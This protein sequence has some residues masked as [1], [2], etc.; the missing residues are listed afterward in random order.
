MYVLSGNVSYLKSENCKRM[1]KLLFTLLALLMLITACVK[2]TIPYIPPVNENFD[3]KTTE[4]VSIK[5]P[6]EIQGKASLSG[7]TKTDS[8]ASTVK[9]YSSALYSESSFIASGAVYQGNDFETVMDL[10]KGT[11]Q[12]F[13]KIV[14]PRGLVTLSTYDVIGNKAVKSLSRSLSVKGGTPE[15]IGGEPIVPKPKFPAGYDVTIRNASELPAILTGNR[16]YFI[17]EGVSI[18]VNNVNLFSNWQTGNLPVLYVKGNFVM[19]NRAKT[20]LSF[21]SV[22]VLSGGS[23]TFRGRIDMGWSGENML[24]VYVQNGGR[25]IMEQG[26]DAG[27]KGLG[28]VNEGALMVKGSNMS[29]LGGGVLFYNTAEANFVNNKIQFTGN[30]TV[31]Y[32]MSDINAKEIEINSGASF[33]NYKNGDVACE[34]TLHVDNSCF[35]KNAGSVESDQMNLV[36][37]ASFYNYEN[38]NKPG[39]VVVKNLTMTNSDTYLYQHGFFTVE[40]TYKAKGKIDN[41]GRM[42][43]STIT[44]GSTANFYCYKGSLIKTEYLSSINHATFNMESESIVFVY[45]NG[46]GNG[47][48][49]NWN[50]KFINNNSNGVEYALVLWG[51]SDKKEDNT[52]INSKGEVSFYGNIENHCPKKSDAQNKKYTNDLCESNAYWGGREHNIPET[53]YNQGFGTTGGNDP[54]DADGDG[55]PEGED[56]D[57]DDPLVTHVSYFPSATTWATY[58]FEDLWP[59]TGDYDMNDIVLGFRIAYYSKGALSA[60]NNHV[61]YMDFD[62]KLRAVGSQMQLALGMQLDDIIPTMISKI[63]NDNTALGNAP[64]NK[65]AGGLESGQT[66]AVFALFNNPAELYGMSTGLNVYKDVNAATVVPV[67]K[68]VRIKF[69]SAVPKEN[70]VVAAMNPFVV[71]SETVLDRGKEIHLATNLP[72]D[73]VNRNYFSDGFVSAANPYK[74]NNGMVWGYMVPAE[75]R[76]PVEMSAITKVY[77]NFEKWYQSAGMEHTNWYDASIPGNVVEE[78]LYDH[79]WK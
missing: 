35:F 19:E 60:T 69:A 58:L 15:N 16:T 62:W 31:C 45:K 52:I 11:T 36:S 24:A 68:K 38:G 14:S 67:I 1:N 4:P 49:N 61:V 9:I 55:V 25:L 10:A 42:E 20:P 7:S 23:V 76:Y 78:Y 66:K 29:V 79:I 70:L 48:T 72:T 77:P 56:V 50:V 75:F 74:A 54:V 41:Y 39:K 33:Y 17:P 21:S 44:D 65:D 59:F 53:I 32:N 13:V 46:N 28:I 5:I 3:W 73:K 8:Y 30:G 12:L 18:G 27:T 64:I 2:N 63:E 51:V 43:C 6:M 47:N 37:R 22:V 57:D 40:Q 34:K 26:F 71:A